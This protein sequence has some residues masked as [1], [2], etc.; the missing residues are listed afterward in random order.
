MIKMKFTQI[1]SIIPSHITYAFRKFTTTVTI[2]MLACKHAC[3]HAM[4]TCVAYAFLFMH[5]FT[6][7][8]LR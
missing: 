1:Y 2:A 3:L 8:L 7:K 5:I 6:S 4:Y